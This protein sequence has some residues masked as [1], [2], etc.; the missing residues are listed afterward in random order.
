ME[1]ADNMTLLIVHL[2]DSEQEVGMSSSAA[3]LVTASLCPSELEWELTFLPPLSFLG[4]PGIPRTLLSL[5]RVAVRRALGKYRLHL[6][7]LLP[8]PDP[9]KKFLLHE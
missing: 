1:G 2:L 7:P 4:S 9:I 3:L 5:C 8:L 6:I